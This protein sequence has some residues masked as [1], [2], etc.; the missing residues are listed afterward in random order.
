MSFGNT[1]F[2]PDDFTDHPGKFCPA[3][4]LRAR[5]GALMEYME[6]GANE[7]A[8]VP[9]V[10]T[11]LA[12]WINLHA[13]TLAED[14]DNPPADRFLRLSGDAFPEGRQLYLG[15]M[16]SAI[17]DTCGALQQKAAELGVCMVDDENNVWVN[18]TAGPEDAP[19]G[20][21]LKDSTAGVTTHV[22]QDSVRAVLVDDAARNE[23]TDGF[24]FIVVEPVEPENSPVPGVQFAQAA[25][26]NGDWV[27]EYRAGHTMHHLDEPVT[28]IDDVVRYLGEYVD[29]DVGAF[30]S[31]DWATM[32][33]EVQ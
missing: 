13:D 4:E 26:L 27:V 17:D 16:Y 22:T 21:R 8:P 24:P 18:A 6:D 15:V 3:S 19:A 30:L 11:E 28:G 7:S 29:G 10:L 12:D 5:E 25:R 32:D 23:G 14:P 31:H 2:L 1:F 33:L 20:L 9:P